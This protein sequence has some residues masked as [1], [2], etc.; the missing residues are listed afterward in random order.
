MKKLKKIWMLVLLAAGFALAF[1]GCSNTKDE[2]GTEQGG[3][4]SSGDETGGTGGSNSNTENPGGS[5]SSGDNAGNA[6]NADTSSG[7]QDPGSGNNSDNTGNAGDSGTQQEPDSGFQDDVLTIRNGVVVKCEATAEG[8]IRIPSNVTAI[9]E[10][11]FDGCSK[12]EVIEIQSGVIE[13]GAHAF[14]GCTSLNAVEIPDTVT[15]IGANAFEYCVKLEK[16]N[17]R[18]TVG[19]VVMLDLESA[20]ID[21]HTISIMCNYEKPNAGRCYFSEWLKIKNDTVEECDRTVD[22]YIIIPEGI[23]TIAN[24]AFYKCTEVK[25]VAIPSSV[26]TVGSALSKLSDMAEV[27]YTGS[28]SF[29]LPPLFD[30]SF[31]LNGQL[32]K[33]LL[34]FY[35]NGKLMIGDRRANEITELTESDFSFVVDGMLHVTPVIGASFSGWTNLRSVTIPWF[36]RE[37]EDG[38]FQNCTGLTSIIVHPSLPPD[39]PDTPPSFGANS[40]DGVTATMYVP[41]G[42]K[43]D[44][45]TALINAGG[46]I[47]VVEQ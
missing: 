2:T 46:T 37:I 11:A 21:V 47:T 12:L 32:A 3:G 25:G 20:G 10:S 43:S 8:Y 28:R 36:I 40:F 5:G 26:Y 44:Y 24:N 15:S 38:A 29:G 31:K 7:S 16:V 1:N 14:R 23:S 27:T 18:G 30:W 41:V 6:G 17:C 39:Y 13:I 45:E 34:T 35:Y 33:R 42:T 22:G 9:G 4:A 19:Q